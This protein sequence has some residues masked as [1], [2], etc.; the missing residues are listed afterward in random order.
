VVKRREPSRHWLKV[1][2]VLALTGVVLG[3]A[4]WMYAL[5]R[6]HD[7]VQDFERT[8]FS[9]IGEVALDAP[10][11]HTIWFEGSRLSS[12]GNEPAEYRQFSKLTLT[13]PSGQPVPYEPVAQ[14]WTYNTTV[15]EGRA[16]WTFDAPSA[17]KYAI[18]IE[19]D[20][21]NGWNNIPARN[22]AFGKGEGLPV[23]VVRPIVLILAT[24]SGAAAALAWTTVR[25][26]ER[27]FRTRWSRRVGAAG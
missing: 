8:R 9:S 10:G 16:I 19:F 2:A 17:G 20:F 18:R 12:K 13:D 14:D 21:M 4:W 25:R 11:R 27:T 26:R 7:T 15:R 23:R 1:S 22:L 24:T 3:G 6:I 5:V